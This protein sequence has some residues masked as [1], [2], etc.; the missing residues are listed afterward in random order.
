MANARDVSSKELTLTLETWGEKP[1]HEQPPLS[2]P[3]LGSALH[4]AVAQGASPLSFQG[5]SSGMLL[6]PPSAL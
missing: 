4:E 1:T 3:V 6:F 5:P 2:V